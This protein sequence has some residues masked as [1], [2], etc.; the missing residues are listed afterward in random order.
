MRSMMCIECSPIQLLLRRFQQLHIHATLMRIPRMRGDGIFDF[1][2]FGHA[3][4]M[5]RGKSHNIEREFRNAFNVLRRKK[6]RISRKPTIY[7]WA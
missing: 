6:Y 2:F 5:Q 3:S 1:S 7:V 4:E